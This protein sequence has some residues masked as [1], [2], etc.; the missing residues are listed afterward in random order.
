MEKYRDRIERRY[1][2]RRRRERYLDGGRRKEDYKSPPV[3]YWHDLWLLIP[4]V[5][6]GL[7]MLFLTGC[8]AVKRLIKGD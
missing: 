8:M 3:F 5:L 1:A 4:L 6:S 7:A 2:S